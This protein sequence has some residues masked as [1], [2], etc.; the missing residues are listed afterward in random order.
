MKKIKLVLTL[1][2]LISVVTYSC[3]KDNNSGSTQSSLDDHL[4]DGKWKITLFT[5]DANDETGHFT[6]AFQHSGIRSLEFT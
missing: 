4:N 1:L 5:E 3:K 6:D 2:A